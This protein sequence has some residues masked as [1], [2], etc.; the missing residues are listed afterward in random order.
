MS[1]HSSQKNSEHYSASSHEGVKAHFADNIDAIIE[2]AGIG[3]WDWDLPSGRVIFSPQWEHI[4]GYE[5][6]ELEQNVASW[7]NTVLPED[8]VVANEEIDRHIAGKTPRYE[9]EFR[10]Q[11]KDGRVIWAQDKGVVVEWDNEGN[12]KRLIGV[13]QDISRIRNAEEEMKQKT[14]Q[15]DFVARMCGL[16]TWDWDISSGKI[17]YSDEFF[18]MM[19]YSGDDIAGGFNEWESLNHPDDVDDVNQSLQAYI[20][21]KSETYTQ[22]TRMLHKNGHYIWTLD[23]GRAV[24]WD[25]N[26]KPT[27]MIGGHLNIDNLKQTELKLQSALQQIENY[28]EQLQLRLEDT[29]ATLE[30][31][32]LFNKEL[33]AA[34]PYINVLFDDSFQPIDC[35]PSAVEYFKFESREALLKELLPF[36][37]KII[38]AIQPNGRPSI[39]L[40]QRFMD[41]IQSGYCEFETEFLLNEQRY[42]CHIVLKKIPTQSSFNIAAF[43]MDLSDMRDAKNEILHQDRLLRHINSIAT[44]LL[45]SKISDFERSVYESLKILGNAV[46][47]SSTYVWRH[48]EDENSRMDCHQLY[49]WRE[50]VSFDD[51]KGTFSTDYSVSYIDLQAWHKQMTQGQSVTVLVRQMDESRRAP[52]EAEGVKTVFVIPIFFRGAFWGF[53]GFNDHYHERT[54]SETEEKILQSSGILIVSAILRNEIT[55]NL[56]RARE[57]ALASVKA[58]SDFLSR[59]SHEIRTP[60]NAIIGMTTIAKKTQDA[61]KIHFSLEKIE[62]AS[63]QLLDIINDILDMSKIE[64]N[65]LDIVPIAFDFEM[66]VHN[67]FTIIETRAAEKEQNLVVNFESLFTRKLVCDE[68]RLS[69]VLTNLLTN[70]V[71]FTP[72]GGSVTLTAS[73]TPI[74]ADNARLRIE[75]RDDG[76]GISDEQQERLFVAFE[77]GDGGITRKYGGTGL[78][79]SISKKIVDL[80]GGNLWVESTI[81]KG[82]TFVM[83]V[84]ISWGEPINK[85]ASTQD[86]NA[87]LRIL[88]V[89]DSEDVLLYFQNVLAGFSVEC[90]I[91]LN[92]DVA[93]EMVRKSAESGNPYELV[94]LDWNMPGTSGEETMQKIRALSEAAP[95]IILMSVSDWSDIKQDARKYDVAG[96]LSKPIFPSMLYN[97]I[98]QAT[99]RTLAPVQE[100]PLR[101]RWPDKTLLLAEDVEINREILLGL[102]EET[103]V[104]VECAENGLEAVSMFAASPQLYSVILMDIQMPEMDGLAAT[105][106]IRGLPCE[107]ADS[108]PIVA[109]TA[110]AFNEDVDN[111]L[112]AGMNGHVAKPIDVDTLMRTLAFYLE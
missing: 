48:E 98:V 56:V 29:T 104:A 107:R 63:R 72:Q 42:P 4:M 44:T 105:R 22:E 82:A 96:F 34:N 65:Q 101:Y 67:V 26:G 108:I 83:E 1:E 32:Q 71:K 37:Q 25:E 23:I 58:K 55:Q 70:A 43:M 73:Q 3:L 61:S 66:M 7:E 41:T 103:G 93:T 16:A 6:G 84:D 97:T 9:V 35:N 19:G 11:R 33:F 14:D 99:H 12:P 111:C 76:I 54:F 75:V 51:A 53:I 45:S 52:I 87:G 74:D 40:A 64:A 13:L 2:T 79:L 90:D 69:Q 46:G 39:P 24:S 68:L 78:G 110:N 49:K 36:L 28:N 10:A 100:E 18:S 38:P 5:A 27:R 31:S 62:V 86:I 17:T 47:V 80:L 15:L 92:G 77:Q 8:L 94:F 102:L 57:E 20:D 91:A 30:G 85:Q 21:N 81:G 50:G 106:R 88:A 95:P 89:D 109:M 112:K 59:M 60:M